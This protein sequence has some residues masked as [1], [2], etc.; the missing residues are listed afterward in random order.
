[1]SAI[2]RTGLPWEENGR[3]GSGVS[4][5]SLTPSERCVAYVCFGK[6]E[7]YVCE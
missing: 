5:S 4:I 6:L 3:V 7:I 1:M 2:K